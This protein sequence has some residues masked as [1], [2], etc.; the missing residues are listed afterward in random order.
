METN[1]K[2]GT[3][4]K[5]VFAS[6]V[7]VL[8][9]LN[10]LTLYFL[11]DTRHQKADLGTQKTA[12]ERQFHDLS[13]TLT[14]KSEELDQFRGK[15]AELD[16]AITEKQQEIDK[17]KKELASLFNKNKLTQGEL[18]KAQKMIAE[19]KASIDDMTAKVEQLTKQNQELTASNDKLNTDLSLEKSTTSKLTEQNQGL[20]KKVEV[21]SLLPIA[22]VDV[23]AIKKRNNGKEV[24]VKR[25][26]AAES[27][28]ISFETGAN[29]VL[30]PGPMSL[31]VRVINPKGETISVADQGS[32]TILSATTPEP[33][34]YTKKADFEYDQ[35]NKKIIVYWSQDIKTAGTY[36]VEIY[37]NGYVVGQG[38]V[39][40]S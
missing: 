27:L 10:S 6:T 14:L 7:V 33:V 34:K 9:L 26:K 28:R 13:E 31:Y 4:S 40:L 24:E 29:K 23:E 8:L 30:D 18:N 3:V 16:K 12:L 11:L 5:R 35:N 39:T 21:G 2:S 25:V 37:Q 32:G 38:A 36:K 22:K 17:T 19:Y 1:Q 20:S 15:T